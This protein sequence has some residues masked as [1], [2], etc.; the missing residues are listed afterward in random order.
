MAEVAPRLAALDPDKPQRRE[1]RGVT[2]FP[3]AAQPAKLVHCRPGTPV[4]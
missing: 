2:R 4:S 3:G 1:R